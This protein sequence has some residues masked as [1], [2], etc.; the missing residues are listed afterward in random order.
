LGEE[1]SM[2]LRNENWV[3]S[4]RRDHFWGLGLNGGDNI[5]MDFKACELESFCSALEPVAIFC[6][7]SNEVLVS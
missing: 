1:C 2:Y 6:E 5:E 7:Q 3:Q 4:I